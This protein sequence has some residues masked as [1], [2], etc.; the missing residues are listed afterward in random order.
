LTKRSREPC[1]GEVR[2]IHLP[3]SALEH[4]DGDAPLRHGGWRDPQQPE[5]EQHEPIYDVSLMSYAESE[6][7]LRLHQ[8]IH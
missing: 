2:R 7:Y 8:K 6:E 5:D 3:P 4:R 1:Q